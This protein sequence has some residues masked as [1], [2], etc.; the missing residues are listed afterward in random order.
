MTY[1]LKTQSSGI[2][3]PCFRDVL[4]ALQLADRP[5]VRWTSLRGHR[6]GDSHI[7]KSLRSRSTMKKKNNKVRTRLASYVTN[8]SVE[9]AYI[10]DKKLRYTLDKSALK[11]IGECYSFQFPGLCCICC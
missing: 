4:P 9:I 6:N 10:S 11:L 3:G 2:T 5:H 8:N 1:E 7:V